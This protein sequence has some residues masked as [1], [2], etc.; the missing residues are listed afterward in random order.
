MAGLV[1][2]STFCPDFQYYLAAAYRYL[3]VGMP[4]E[5]IILI[6]WLLFRGWY[7]GARIEHLCGMLS[8]CEPRAECSDAEAAGENR[9]FYPERLVPYEID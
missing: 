7:H 2:R 5:G 3:T 4:N 1:E 6:G 9:V 8:I